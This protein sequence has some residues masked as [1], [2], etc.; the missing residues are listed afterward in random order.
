[1]RS[2]VV[3][4][5]VLVLGLLLADAALLLAWHLMVLLMR[6]SCSVHGQVA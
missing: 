6:L 4:V 1:M 5:L 2:D 3:L